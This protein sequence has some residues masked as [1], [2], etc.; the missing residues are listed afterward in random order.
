MNNNG[1]LD[2]WGAK[3]LGLGLGYIG[4]PYNAANS[5]NNLIHPA[6]PPIPTRT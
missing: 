4:A 2:N 6:A 3:N 1:I 5:V